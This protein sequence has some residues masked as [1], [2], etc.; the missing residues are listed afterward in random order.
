MN[1]APAAVENQDLSRFLR[2]GTNNQTRSSFGEW[3]SSRR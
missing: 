2:A 3:T 1:F